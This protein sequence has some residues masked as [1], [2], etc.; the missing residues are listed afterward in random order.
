MPKAELPCFSNGELKRP[1][2]PLKKDSLY[3]LATSGYGQGLAG[4]E[5]NKDLHLQRGI[6]E[7]IE[8]ERLTGEDIEC[9][10]EDNIKPG[11]LVVQTKTSISMSVIENDGSNGCF[12]STSC[13]NKKHCIW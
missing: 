13:A 8:T 3:L 4:S 6:S 7:I 12:T 2:I 1:P 10:D 11:V 5:E 9:E